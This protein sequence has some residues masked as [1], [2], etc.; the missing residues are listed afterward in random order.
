VAFALDEVHAVQAEGFDLDEGL[1]GGGLGV[2]S[3]IVY[4]EGVGVAF[5]AFD[6][7]LCVLVEGGVSWP[8]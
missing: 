2:G 1:A 3:G 8:R 4:E 7:C 5:A 6:V